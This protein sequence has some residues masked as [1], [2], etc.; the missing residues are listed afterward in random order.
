MASF[1]FFETRNFTTRFAGILISSPV[2][3]FRPIRALRLT[4]TSL[5]TPGIVKLRRDPLRG[6]RGLRQVVGD[7]GFRKRL[8]VLC[9]MHYPF[10]VWY[11]PSGRIK[12]GRYS[13]PLAAKRSK[14]NRVP[15]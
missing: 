11:R 4:R 1:A 14:K 8:G 7:V 15:A 12:L 2:A 9:H 5:P 10:S 6:A 3:G 13:R